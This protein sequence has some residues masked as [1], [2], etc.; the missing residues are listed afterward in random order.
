MRIIAGTLKGRVIKTVQG[1]GYRPAMGRVRE[2][3]FSMLESR[4]VLWTETSVLDLF[5]GSGAL[6]FEAL[7]RGASSARLVENAPVAVTCLRENMRLLGLDESRCRIVVADVAKALCRPSGKTQGRVQDAPFGLVFIDPPYTDTRL[8]RILRDLLRNGWLA[9]NGIVVAEVE[10][11]TPFDAAR[12][13]PQLE[14]LTER[15]FGQTRIVLWTLQK[16]EL[17]YSL[18]PLTH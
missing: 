11:H 8:P 7:S 1:P 6:A 10:A 17:P 15:C 18:A 13:H 16:A 12:I 3:L 5:A 2:A 9:P 14:P 4:G